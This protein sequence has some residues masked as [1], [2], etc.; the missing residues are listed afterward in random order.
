MYKYKY[1][2][3]Y[4]YVYMEAAHYRYHPAALRVQELMGTELGTLQ[5]V[6]AE[7]HM[8]DPKAWFSTAT[9]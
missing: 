8:V 5:N 3:I 9:G 6:T 2:Y 1:I 7:F 4:I